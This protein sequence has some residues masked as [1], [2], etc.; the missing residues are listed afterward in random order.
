[1]VNTLHLNEHTFHGMAERLSIAR[2]KDF[3]HRDMVQ[4]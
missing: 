3:E 4:D 2:R 1:M